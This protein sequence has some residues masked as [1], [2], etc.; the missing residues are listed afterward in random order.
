[1]KSD[2]AP[3][4]RADFASLV[5]HEL[6][7]PL[8][9]IVGTSGSA[10]TRW[11]LLTTSGRIVPAFIWGIEVP[12]ASN[13]MVTSPAI[14]AVSAGAPPLYITSRMSTFD[15]IFRSARLR[16]GDAPM[17]VLAW[18]SWP[19]FARAAEMMSVRLFIGDAVGTTRTLGTAAIGII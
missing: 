12:T 10:L 14:T 16:L 15:I 4:D 1:M 18:L 13:P 5:S 19:G 3:P 7:S 9:A 11:L 17:P 8:S 6:R 2:G